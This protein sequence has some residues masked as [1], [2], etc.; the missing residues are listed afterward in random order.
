MAFELTAEEKTQIEAICERYP[1]RAAA[2]LPVLH[3]VQRRIGALPPPAQL[4]V[5][6]VL[7][8]PP[9]RVKEVVSF[10]EMF[11]EAPKGCFHIELCTNI[12]CHLAGADR[13]MKHLETRLGIEVGQTTEDGTFSLMEA[14]CLASCGSGPMA[15]V[16][17]DYY[18]YLTPEAVDALIDRLR[19]RADE[20][21]DTVF[22]SAEAL[23]H[24]GPVDGFTPPA[25]AAETAPPSTPESKAPSKPEPSA[26][27]TNTASSSTPESTAPSEP[28]PSAKESKGADGD[29][30]SLPSFE[31]PGARK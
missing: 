3:L 30:V 15:K 24:V 11:H 10:Y 19:P 2:L 28:E 8:V 27:V 12:S 17:V 9:T 6:R 25:P 18:E 22:E 5:A 7:D 29:K 26:E 21:R 14:E 1:E 23:P 31:P 16:G 13:L 20:F 4:A